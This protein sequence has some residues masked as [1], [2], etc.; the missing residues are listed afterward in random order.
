MRFLGR[1][2]KRNNRL[3][4]NNGQRQY[5]TQP[6]GEIIKVIFHDK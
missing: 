5:I 3:K 4:T 6:T 2:G 1:K